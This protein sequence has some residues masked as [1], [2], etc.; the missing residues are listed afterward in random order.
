MSVA[1]QIHSPAFLQIWHDN[2]GKGGAASWYL[3][4]V[5]LE[6]VQTEER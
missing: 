2:S 5:L 4:K 3:N 1:Q 6:D